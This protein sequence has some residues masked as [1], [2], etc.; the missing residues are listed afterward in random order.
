MPS[1]EYAVP[2]SHRATRT[3]GRAI[4]RAL[5]HGALTAITVLVGLVG[6]LGWLWELRDQ[7]LLGSGPRL[8]DALPLLQLASFDSQPLLRIAVAWCAVGLLAGGALRRYDRIARAAIAGGLAAVLLWLDS[9]AS[10]A[11]THNLRFSDVVAH[12]SVGLGV[13]VE[14]ALF[15]AASALWAP[16]A[17]PLTLTLTRL[18]PKPQ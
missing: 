6:G 17:R 7:R 9:Q 8:H 13:W 4:L 11:L 3:T 1:T 16:R 10:S 5:W 18:R 2:V 14:A 15:A 12:R